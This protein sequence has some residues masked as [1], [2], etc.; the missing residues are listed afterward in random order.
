[1][2][3]G[4]NGDSTTS[5]RGRR[6][7][8]A[9]ARVLPGAERLTAFSDAVVAVAMTALVL[10]LLDI[11]VSETSTLSD[12]WD[13]YGDQFAA[14][15]LSFFV[16]AIFWTVHHKVWFAVR[17]VSGALLWTNMLWLLGI[18]L[19]PFGTV[20][21]YTEH[22]IPVLGFKIYTGMVFFTSL[23]LGLMIY[24]ITNKPELNNGKVVPQPLWFAL[25]FTMWWALVF[26]ACLVDAAGV[27]NTL[28]D[29]SGLAMFALG[30]MRLPRM[31]A[32][33][34]EMRARGIDVTLE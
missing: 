9:P 32:Q 15:L 34:E 7:H 29:W 18:V 11:D 22:G 6:R 28:L 30:W 3:D 25:R 5:G 8:G 1:M 27:G 14:F 33:A 20:M 13:R 2:T 26:V 23:M 4:S 10:P 19:I 17:G 31:R 12:L 21:L 16:T 24:F